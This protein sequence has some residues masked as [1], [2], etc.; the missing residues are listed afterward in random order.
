M[1]ATPWDRL[2]RRIKRYEEHASR[3]ADG[4]GFRACENIKH[5]QMLEAA[6]R[7]ELDRE[8]IRA[9]EQGA[10]WAMIPFGNSK[11]AA[12]QRH[13]AAIARQPTL[14]GRGEGNPR[15]HAVTPS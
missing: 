15:H 12:Q 1:T 6:V 10:T 2:K 13:A 5:L 14:P 9:R 8:I 4:N 11:Q 7:N 3:R